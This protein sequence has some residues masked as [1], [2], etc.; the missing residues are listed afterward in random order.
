MDRT[1]LYADGHLLSTPKLRIS[2][3]VP[4]NQLTY[5]PSAPD[6]WLVAIMSKSTKQSYYPR[7]A[8][9]WAHV[10]G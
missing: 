10:D 5:S 6:Y 3:Y 2:L 7:S 8:L 1:E 4:N 9:I